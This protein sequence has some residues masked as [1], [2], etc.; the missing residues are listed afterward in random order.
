MNFKVVIYVFEQLEI[1]YTNDQ[2]KKVMVF[3]QWRI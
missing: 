1:G 3:D 2:F